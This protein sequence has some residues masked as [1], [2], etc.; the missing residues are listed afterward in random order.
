M[1]LC[2]KLLLWHFLSDFNYF[3]RV[4]TGMKATVYLFKG[5][6]TSTFD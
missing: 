6:I 1:P 2:F 5:L 4:E 3:C